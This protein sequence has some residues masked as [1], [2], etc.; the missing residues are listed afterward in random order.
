VE[1]HALTA[2]RRSKITIYG[3]STREVPCLTLAARSGDRALLR[4]LLA[5]QAKITPGT[6]A[7]GGNADVRISIGQTTL[8]L[9]FGCRK[10]TWSLRSA[11]VC[12]GEQAASFT[13][14]DLAEAVAA[15]PGHE[16]LQMATR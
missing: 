13:R 10:K 11:K 16:P 15:S 5:G 1:A 9:V 14:S 12:S 7:H 6:S 2:D 3:W 4:R 8:M